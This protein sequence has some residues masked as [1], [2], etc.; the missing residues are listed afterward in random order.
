MFLSRREALLELNVEN[1]DLSFDDKFLA[2]EKLTWLPWVGVNFQATTSR[3]LVL[4]ESTYNWSP[5]SQ[6]VQNRINKNDH[7]R[8]VH[9][10]N[11]IKFKGKSE[12][13][14][15]FERAVFNTKKLTPIKSKELWH[16][17]AY[18]NLVLRCMKNVK[19][20]PKYDDYVAGWNETFH[21]FD[22][23]GIEQCFCYG[24]EDKK[25]QAFK[26]VAALHNYQFEVRSFPKIG[27]NTP[28]IITLTVNEKP[29]KIVF[30][31]HPSSFFSWRKWAAF[32]QSHAPLI[33]L[34]SASSATSTQPIVE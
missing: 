3:T 20:R 28:K 1:L 14:R 11:A 9:Q 26:D 7:L 24:L 4:G 12:Y 21:L 32:M 13:T 27:K 33:T 30:L 34:T 18:H 31:R 17:V 6:V 29:I 25:I 5:S 19:A 8:L 23:L 2:N 15:N 16:S 22:L 10:N